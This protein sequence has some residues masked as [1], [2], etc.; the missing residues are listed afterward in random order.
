MRVSTAYVLDKHDPVMKVVRRTQTRALV[1]QAF[2]MR[3]M[4]MIDTMP[5]WEWHISRMDAEARSA[6]WRTSL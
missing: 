1:P 6:K 5:G 3:Y 4:A 2:E